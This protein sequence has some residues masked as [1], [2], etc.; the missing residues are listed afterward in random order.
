MEEI[1]DDKGKIGIIWRNELMNIKST[2]S[3]N[4]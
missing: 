1:K 3:Y 4:L 2:N